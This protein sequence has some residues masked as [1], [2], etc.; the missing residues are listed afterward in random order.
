VDAVP[1]LAPGLAHQVPAQRHDLVVGEVGVAQHRE[2]VEV[3]LQDGQVVV[4]GP[5]L[6][7]PRKKSLQKMMTFHNIGPLQRL[8]LARFLQGGEVIVGHVQQPQLVQADQIVRRDPPQLV[9]A[10]VEPQELR[11]TGQGAI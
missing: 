4:A 8:Y 9:E 1:D 7:Q 5:Q 11:Q 2:P 6:L 10:Q 3:A